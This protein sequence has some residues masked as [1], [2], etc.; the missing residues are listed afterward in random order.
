MLKT[1]NTKKILNKETTLKQEGRWTPETD[2]KIIRYL[3]KQTNGDIIEI[4]CHTGITT[5]ELLDA[6]PNKCVH[7][8]DYTGKNPTV[9]NEQIYEIPNEFGK[10]VKNNNRVYLYNIKSE[11]FDYTSLKSPVTFIF[12]D[13]DHSY[14]GVKKDTENAIEYFKNNKI[15]GII[16]WH[17]YNPT[18]PEWVKVYQYVN[19]LSNTYDI[20]VYKDS[21][22]AALFYE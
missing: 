22:V 12:I 1:I 14:D 5:L 21:W 16:A 6:N 11:D 20:N 17:D 19:E 3:S 13:G 18:H 9:V 7:A 10:F 4:G 15:K 2:V 8:I